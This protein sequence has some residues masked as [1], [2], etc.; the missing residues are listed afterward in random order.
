MH[1]FSTVTD[2]K[3]LNIS[4][5]ILPVVRVTQNTIKNKNRAVTLSSI[6]GKSLLNLD[7]SFFL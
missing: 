4:V 3:I 5:V 6:L 7:Y 2:G 1:L